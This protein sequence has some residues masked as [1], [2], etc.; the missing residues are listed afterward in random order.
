MKISINEFFRQL[1]TSQSGGGSPIGSNISS[2]ESLTSLLSKNLL[3]QKTRH[4]NRMM[5][6]NLSDN[7]L[8]QSIGG[9]TSSI[10]PINPITPLTLNSYIQNSC[11]QLDEKSGSSGSKLPKTE[12]S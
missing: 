11:E 12:F 10:S 6:F 1:G 9:G 5:V 4:S 2:C 7:N 8:Q 3:L